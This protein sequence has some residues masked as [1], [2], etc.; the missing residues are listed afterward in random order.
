MKRLVAWTLL[1]S[2]LS[3]CGRSA[4]PYAREMG[5]M[6]LLRTM[7]LDAAQDG[8]ELTVSTGKQSGDRPALVLSA[9]GP[10]VASAARAVQSLGDSYVYFGHVDQMLLGEELAARGVGP[11]LD[12]LAREP[13][14]G[15]GVDLWV[16]RDGRAA[17]AVLAGGDAGVPARLDRLEADAGAGGAAIGCTALQL[18][19]A[20]AR[21]ASVCIPAL[22]LAPAREGDGGAGAEQTLL[23]DGYAVIRQGKLVCFLQ[24]DEALGLEL[25]QQRAQG[26]VADVDLRDGTRVSLR[27]EETRVRCEPVFQSGELTGLDVLCT[28]SARVTQTERALSREQIEEATQSFELLEGERMVATLERAQ[29]WD[30]D[31]LGLE[32]RAQSSCPSRKG[33]IERVWRDAFRSLTIRVEVTGEVERSTGMMDKGAEHGHRAG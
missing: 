32:Q 28:L 6:A 15:L 29:Y 4:V 13:Q 24:G 8:V 10:S 22:T 18:M 23:A 7:G 14:L 21:A 11:I 12:H 26:H 2:L 20:L 17:Q 30:A 19:S 9:S 31:F 25:L 16:V 1:L 3:G 33:E 5:D 27:L